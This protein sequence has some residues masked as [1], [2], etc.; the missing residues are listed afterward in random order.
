[1]RCAARP[2]N[3][4]LDFL[5]DSSSSLTHGQRSELGDWVRVIAVP[6]SVFRMPSDSKDAFSRAVGHTFQ[7]EGFDETG[8]LEIDLWPKLSCDTI[9][10]EPDCVERTRRQ[11]QL[12]RAFETKLQEK[13]AP[14]PTRTGT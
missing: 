13:A 5:D 1:M 8:C 10:V 9:W 12:S 6:L 7:I 11:A 2:L 3:K 14:S 4:S